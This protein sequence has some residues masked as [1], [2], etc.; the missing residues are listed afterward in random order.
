MLDFAGAEPASAHSVSAALSI[1]EHTLMAIT[2]SFSLVRPGISALRTLRYKERGRNHRTARPSDRTARPNR[3]VSQMLDPLS[4]VLRSVR[5]A[6][7]V[8]LD[9]RFTAP[10]C[11]ATRIG[12]E[13]CS[14]FMAGLVQV[15]GYHV[16]IEGRMLISLDHQ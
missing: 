3:T 13:E 6:G 2:H 14:P 4:D 7:G 5:L 16:V 11:V 8:F 1:F 10:W 9:A 15:I 12:V